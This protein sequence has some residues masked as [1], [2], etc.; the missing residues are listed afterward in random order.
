MFDPEFDKLSKVYEESVKI[1]V[2]LE[3]KKLSKMVQRM[4]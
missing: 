1:K 2:S 3:G 4:G